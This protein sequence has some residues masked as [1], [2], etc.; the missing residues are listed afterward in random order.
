MLFTIDVKHG[1]TLW[2]H[3]GVLSIFKG[4]YQHQTK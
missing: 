3:Q 1:Q 2:N 4:N